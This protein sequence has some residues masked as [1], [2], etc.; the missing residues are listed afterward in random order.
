MKRPVTTL[1][2]AGAVPFF[3]HTIQADIAAPAANPPRSTD[4]ATFASIRAVETIY[5]M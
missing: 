2:L 3:A 4:T 1:L 5:P